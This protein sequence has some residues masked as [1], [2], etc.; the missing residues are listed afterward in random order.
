MEDLTQ[1]VFTG[2]RSNV[3]FAGAEKIAQSKKLNTTNKKK[4]QE[5][6]SNFRAYATHRPLIKKFPRRFIKVPTLDYQIGADLI[7]IKHPKSNYNKRYILGVVDHFSRKAWLEAL[8]NKSADEV[9]NAMKKIFKRGN[10]NCKFFFSD[11]GKEFV[12]QKLS[13]YFKS[14]NIHPFVS[15]SPTKCC[16]NERFNRT[17]MTRIARYLTHVRSKR[18]VHKLGDFERQYNNTFHRTIGM[19]PLQV[20]TENAPQVWENIY[21]KKIDALKSIKTPSLSEGD[22][23]LLPKKKGIFDKGYSQTFGEEI[24]KIKKVIKS[25]PVT[26]SIVTKEGTEI[27]GSFYKQELVKVPEEFLV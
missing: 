12:N 16:I 9:L 1:K 27:K 22:Y 19:S 18:F 21:K 15:N 4:V 14:K 10:I 8:K 6:L 11:F 20:T 5:Q 17:I 24:F 13:N 3:A 7:E 26:Y 23:V 2:K 25:R